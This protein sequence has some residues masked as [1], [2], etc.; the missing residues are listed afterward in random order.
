MPF[1]ALPV[2]YC[3]VYFNAYLRLAT[4][5]NAWQPAER[6]SRTFLLFSVE[7]AIIGNEN[8]GFD[9]RWR[10]HGNRAFAR[11][12]D[13]RGRAVGLVVGRSLA[14]QRHQAHRAARYRA[15]PHARVGAPRNRLEVGARTQA[16]ASHAHSCD[17]NRGT[18]RAGVCTASRSTSRISGWPV[19]PKPGSPG[20]PNMKRAAA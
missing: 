17:A 19:G 9:S 4:G 11:F 18:A 5:G 16:R 2:R 14:R 6:L 10:Y 1:V 3:C 20:G 13:F 7:V 12:F 15:G 8:C